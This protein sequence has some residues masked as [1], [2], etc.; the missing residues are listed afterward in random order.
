[1]RHFGVDAL[2]LLR[3]VGILARP[4]RGSGDNFSRHLI[5]LERDGN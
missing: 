1:L 5:V 4:F 3:H 2:P